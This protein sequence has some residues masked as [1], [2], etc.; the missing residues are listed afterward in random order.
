MCNSS[1]RQSTHIKR[2]D[3]EVKVEEVRFK[4]NLDEEDDEIVRREAL[5]RIE[6]K[7]IM[8]YQSKNT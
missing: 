1:P 5:I 3:E 8:D 6:H 2:E 4:R 7:R